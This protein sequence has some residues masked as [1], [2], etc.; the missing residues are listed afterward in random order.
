MTK[1]YIIYDLLE[2]ISKE[3]S[4]N[5][6]V[7]LVN[8]YA[9]LILEAITG[10]S[11]PKLIATHKINLTS[12]QLEKVD[13][14]IYQIINKNEPIQYILGK[15]PFLDLE[16]FIQP[17]TLIPRPET[18]EWCAWLIS[19]LKKL[20]LSPAD[21]PDP[22]TSLRTKGGRGPQK[23]EAF[24]GE[25]GTIEHK[26]FSI[27]D[28]GTGS[29]CIALSLAKA[30]PEAEVVAVDISDFALD[31]AQKNAEHNKIKNI[32]FI[33]SD[34]FSNLQNLSFDL[35]VSNPPYIDEKLFNSLDASVK[36]WEDSKALICKD[37][38]LE[39]IKKIIE[40]S[41]NFIKN[42]K[43]FSDKKLPQLVLEIDYT[44]GPE[45]AKLMKQNNFSDSKIIKDFADKDRI[46]CG[47]K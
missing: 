35:I 1:E 20:K 34:L 42:N 10:L 41:K 29:G 7:N 31:L 2:F 39:I 16:L 4:K 21:C 43:E 40:Q 47:Y 24:W 37:N 18:E 15:V 12:D 8:N 32:K 3:L 33:K 25:M 38:G 6:D 19:E 44:Q 26:N 5:L 13:K 22:S 9:W 46:V 23:R 30:F 14:Y 11:K 27:L 17:P 28:I 45:V 36:N